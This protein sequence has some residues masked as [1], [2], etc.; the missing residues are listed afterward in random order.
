MSSIVVSRKIARMVH[1]TGR[2]EATYAC[3]P[4]DDAAFATLVST[5][6]LNIERD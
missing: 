3:A 6:G 5:D 4:V 1:G 2:N